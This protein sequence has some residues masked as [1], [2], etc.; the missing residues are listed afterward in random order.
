MADPVDLSAM[1]TAAAEA[2][3]VAT[4]PAVV[5][6]TVPAAPTGDLAAAAEAGAASTPASAA[7]AADADGD[8]AAAGATAPPPPPSE[9][10]VLASVPAPSGKGTVVAPV[11]RGEGDALSRALTD[12][13][14][15][16]LYPLL[17][18]MFT[19]VGFVA[20]KRLAEAWFYPDGVTVAPTVAYK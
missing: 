4:P 14:S 12:V 11:S 1:A 16:F 18:G 8:A 20:G 19:G 17:T 10:P 15:V 3:P 9:P 5:D 6:A 7:A 2:I 13:K